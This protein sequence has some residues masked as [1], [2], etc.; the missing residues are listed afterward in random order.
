MAVEAVSV[1]QPAAAPAAVL[2]PRSALVLAGWFGLVG[3]Y[4]DVGM[5]LLRR[6]VVGATLHY[7]QGRDFWWTV[8]LANLAVV[9][10]LGLVVALANRLRRGLVSLR[11]AS[12][13]FATMALWGPLLRAPLYGAASLL[14]A[15]GVARG[16]SR[17][18]ARHPGSFQRLAR[19]GLIALAVAAGGTAAACQARQALAERRALAALPP[20]PAGTPNVLLLV[21]DTV[22][23]GNLS[24]YGY[25]RETTPELARWARRGVRFDLALAPAPWTFPSHASFLTGRWPAALNAHWEPTL[26]PAAPTLAGFLASQGYA[27]AGFAANTHWCSYETGMNRGFVHYEDYPLSPRTFLACTVPGRWILRNL[28]GSGGYYAAKWLRSQ[29][30]DARAVNRAFLDWLDRKRPAGRPFF[31]FLNYLDAHEPFLPPPDAPRFGTRPASA[32]ESRMLLEYWDRDKLTLRPRDVELARDAYDDCIAALDRQIG[33]L[34]D[35]LDR[36]GELARSVVII[37]SDH[38]EQFGE[39]GVFNHGYSLYAHEIRVPL[40]VLAPGAPAGT[41]VREPVSLRDLPATVTDLLGL[42]G[43]SP[44]PGRTLR[45]T[46][47]GPTGETP[48][49]GPPALSEV[50]I[51]LVIPPQRGKGPKQRGYTLSLVAEGLH[52]TVDLAGTEELY[53]LAADPLEL[54]DLRNDPSRTPI[55]GRFRD[56]LRRFLRAEPDPP[57]AGGEYRKRLRALLDTMYP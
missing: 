29:S 2:S 40:V 30:R 16:I 22:R 24:L 14:L 7:E 13:L 54:H 9:L 44:L 3:G 48:E 25:E 51:P 56:A 6:D 12:W 31:A 42:A 8:P 18:A 21:L 11:G 55:L 57:D 50:D 36:R 52:Y 5:I 39:H 46:W 17:R 1:E 35:E 23:A 34:L 37:T 32:A 20:P 10:A 45:Q 41:V 15:A 19:Y 47:T 38:G 49:G 28:P 27:T 53:D 26:D 33:R 4:L 43:A